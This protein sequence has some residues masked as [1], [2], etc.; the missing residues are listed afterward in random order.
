MRSIACSRP[1]RTCSEPGESC[2]RASASCGSWASSSLATRSSSLRAPAPLGLAL[3]LL[4]LAGDLFLAAPARSWFWLSS[5]RAARS[6]K[7]GF[8]AN[9]GVEDER[10][11]DER[12]AGEMRLASG[13]CAAGSSEVVHSTA[14]TPNVVTS[15]ARHIPRRKR[16]LRDAARHQERHGLEDRQVEV[17]A[18]QEV[19]GDQH[20]RENDADRECGERRDPGFARTRCT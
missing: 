19:G 15:S 2:Q 4:V 8:A 3:E 18:G 20:R 14:S 13:G 5:V 9:P 16:R 6:A 10:D 17:R 1:C 12:D 11:Q 7:I